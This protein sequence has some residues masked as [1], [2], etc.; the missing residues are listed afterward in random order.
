MD[1]K[2]ID[3]D[4]LHFR[5]AVAILEGRWSI[6]ILNEL[7]GGK[8]RFGELKNALKG[9]SPKILSTR[10]KELQQEGIIEKKVYPETPP[11]VEY[12]LSPNGLLIEKVVHT[13]ANWSTTLEKKKVSAMTLDLH[14]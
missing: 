5:K 12:R 13:I 14:Q 9:I 8:K 1:K 6:L 3:F 2:G 11:R 7:L 4:D 10:L